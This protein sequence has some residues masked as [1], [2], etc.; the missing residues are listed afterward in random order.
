MKKV[1]FG[2]FS[3]GAI[4]LVSSCSFPHWFVSHRHVTV[5]AAAGNAPEIVQVRETMV[6]KSSFSIEQY[7]RSKTLNVSEKSFSV[8]Y[9]GKQIQPKVYASFPNEKY[10]RRL[11][12]LT[13][14]PSM[15]LMQVSFKVKRNQ[16][17]TIRIVEHDVPQANDSIV[18]NVEIP[19]TYEKEDDIDRYNYNQLNQLSNGYIIDPT[20][21]NGLYYNLR[22]ED[23]VCVKDFVVDF[24][25]V[26]ESI[27]QGNMEAN[28]N[29]IM[30]K[31]DVP[32]NTLTFIYNANFYNISISNDCD[33]SYLKNK[34]RTPNEK[35]KIR[36]KFFEKVKQPYNTDYPF[37]IIESISPNL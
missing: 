15:T 16:G 3:F 25:H 4:L 1:V 9:Q 29:L 23:G 2:I 18:I 19:E 32:K 31:D 5:E 37:A 30:E 33:M 11:K 17:D 21:R 20:K 35:I 8:S 26:E 14:I 27:L 34:E 12:E 13:T 36:V 28:M 24:G 6:R 10:S 22:F 7:F